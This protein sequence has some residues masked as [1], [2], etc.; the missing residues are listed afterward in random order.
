MTTR[1]LIAN[2][3]KM[4]QD[5]LKRLESDLDIMQRAGCSYMGTQLISKT[6][7]DIQDDIK[8]LQERL[9]TAL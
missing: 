4:Q 2:T 6:I 7:V 1:L 5:T 3:I 8:Q 9:E